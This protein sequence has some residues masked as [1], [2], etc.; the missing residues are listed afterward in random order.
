MFGEVRWIAE[1][2]WYLE[3][4]IYPPITT[5]TTRPFSCSNKR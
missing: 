2:V 4:I 3:S 5:M 1:D